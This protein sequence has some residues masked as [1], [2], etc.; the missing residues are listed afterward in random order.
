MWIRR[1]GVIL[2]LLLSLVV[3]YAVPASASD[4]MLTP[5][6]VVFEGRDRSHVV[7][8]ANTGTRPSTFRI[9]FFNQRMT[10]EGQFESITA[11]T[12]PTGEQFAEDMIRYSPRIVTIPP[13]GSQ[14]VRLQLR[15]PADIQS[16]EYRSHLLFQAVD[17]QAG[18]SIETLD[19]SGETRLTAR[20]IPIYG[21]S[22]PVIVRHG[23]TSMRVAMDNVELLSPEGRQRELSLL[24]SREGNQSAFG[25]LEVTFRP[26]GA[27]EDLSLARRR[28]V[29]IYTPNTERLIRIPLNTPQGVELSDGRLR[30]V[31]RDAAG[32]SRVLAENSIDL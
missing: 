5:T 32:R 26:R 22:I 27:M 3:G 8:V 2:V 24:L 30:V 10:R 29:S 4:I 1:P 18:S 25:D 6:R 7:H 20:L 16:G 31:Y 23:Q 28:G 19:A 9:S 21:I 14:V 11:P 17:A 13:G 15:K 12:S